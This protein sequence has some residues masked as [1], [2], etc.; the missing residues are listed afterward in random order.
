[1]AFQGQSIEHIQPFMTKPKSPPSRA[2]LGFGILPRE[3]EAKPEVAGRTP[4]PA[5]RPKVLVVDQDPSLRRIM[6]AHL[7]GADYAVATEE[8]GQAA[9]DACVRSRPNL[10]ICDL[11]LGDMDGLTLLKELK[12]RWPLVTVIILTTHA[13]IPEA[14]RATQLGAFSFLVKPVGKQELMGHVERGIA[15]SSFAQTTGDWRDQIASRS[16]LLEDRVTIANRAA[17]GTATLLLSGASGTGKELLARA[18]HAA[19][20]RRDQPFVVVSCK[21]L[22]DTGL[23]SELFGD[24]GSAGG[25]ARPGAFARA[26]RG[27]L[28]LGEVGELPAGQQLALLRALRKE[29]NPTIPRLIQEAAR[30]DVRLICTTSRDLRGAVEAGEFLSDL[31]ERISVLPIEMPPLGR[32]REDVPLLISHFLEQAKEPGTQD[33]I[34]TPQAIATLA[35]T[36]WPGQ[37]RQLFDLVKQDVV[38]SHGQAIANAPSTPEGPDSIPTYDEAREAFARAYLADNLQRTEGNV[39]QAARIAKRTRTD[40]YKL[41]AKYRLRPDDFKPPSRGRRGR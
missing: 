16:K 5:R 26:H 32:R 30:S 17:A 11:R 13:T 2:S 28:L 34:Y 19:S 37:V 22:S 10:V 21:G 4:L 27:T 40:F 18:I 39:T 6:T 7:G 36:G 9:L 41:L 38:I 23:D 33:R 12:S 15:A 25:E 31:L 24:E 8:S 20:V 3:K 1:M 14:V 35:T 29:I